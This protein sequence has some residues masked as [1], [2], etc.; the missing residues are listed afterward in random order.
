MKTLLFATALALTPLAAAQAV[1][2]DVATA[3]TAPGRP[4]EAVAMD[5]GRHPAE[6]LRFMG[7]QRGDRVLDLFTYGAYYG[8]IM[9]RAVGP[10]GSVLGWNPREFTQEPTRAAM[11][12]VRQRSP[13][14]AFF[15]TQASAFALPVQAFDFAMLHLDYHDTYLEAPRI[16]FRM[17]P[18]GFVR[19]VFQSLK[20]GGTIAVIDHAANPGGD[21]REVVRTLH[22]I[23][24]A[25]LRADFERAGFVFDGELNLLRNPEDDH[26]KS[27]FDP[28]IRG[29]TD[30]FVYR[31]RRPR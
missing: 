8:E 15:I 11:T 1:P 24:P 21:T 30:R 27:V 13:N 12:A 10:R 5:A 17:D 28:T 19:A 20:P 18:D 3:V 31:F 2:A 29:R 23:D 6:V 7:L 16:G 4:A 22:R 26:S 9:A 14:Y 25:T